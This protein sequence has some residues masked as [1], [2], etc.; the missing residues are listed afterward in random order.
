M[1]NRLFDNVIIID[2][3]MGN[4]SVV[5]GTSA[6]TTFNVTA[7]AFWSAN[8][9]GDF[10][11]SGASTADHIA[12]FSTINAGS[13]IVTGLQYLTFSSPVRLSQIKCPTIT[14]GSAWIYLA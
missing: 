2:S 6:N 11:I 5:G 9:L 12:H 1:A 10:I 8:T 13:G 3:A 7:I 4:I 14:A